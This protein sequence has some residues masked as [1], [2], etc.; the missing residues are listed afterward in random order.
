MYS[1]S[2]I[3]RWSSQVSCSLFHGS[4]KTVLTGSSSKRSSKQEIIRGW[5]SKKVSILFTFLELFIFNL[6]IIF[7][8]IFLVIGAQ[9]VNFS[10]PMRKLWIFISK[11]NMKSTKN[12]KF[13]TVNRN[14]PPLD[15]IN[16]YC[17]NISSM[18]MTKLRTLHFHT[19][20]IAVMYHW[21]VFKRHWI[22]S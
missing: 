4:W 21:M 1:M 8:P 13:A 18:S 3:M 9:Y 10:S 6:Y 14:S 12:V 17:L 7:Y 2:K 15:L 16:I 20:A 5:Q 11:P 22:M 19:I